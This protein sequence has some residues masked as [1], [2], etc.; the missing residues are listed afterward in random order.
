M[1][2]SKTVTA[3]WN[4]R[5]IKHYASFKDEFGNSKYHYTKK[6]DSLK[7]LV[8]ELAPT[9]S[10]LVTVSCDYCG[11]IFDTPYGSYTV[12]TKTINKVCCSHTECMKLKR[13]AINKLTYGFENQFERPEIKTQIIKT[14][15]KKFGVRHHNQIPI[16]IKK[17][18]DNYFR[19]YG[20]TNNSQTKE[21]RDQINKGFQKKYGVDY[22]LETDEFKERAK[23]TNIRKFGTEWATQSPEIKAKTAKTF[24]K[25]SS[26]ASSKQQ[27]YINDLLH[28]ILNFSDGTPNLD[29]AFPEE[30]IYIE[31]DGGGHNLNV[32]FKKMT[33]EDFDKKQM[34]RNYFLSGKGWKGIRIISLQDF[35]PSDEII[36]KMI[37]EAKDYLNSGRHWI[38]YHVDDET[39]VCSQYIKEYNYGQLRKLP[40]N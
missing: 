11:Y 12:K 22:Y 20:I 34:K 2:I 31:Y 9:S 3:K 23:V 7:V 27:R 16:I 24:Y 37:K 17:R 15:F 36:I 8:T 38:E 30:M 5:N 4:R 19:K 26:C 18:E 33:Q 40:K 6:G 28:G 35:L 39:I 32:I 10:V 25:N 21:W 14:C 1:L 13:N 29:I